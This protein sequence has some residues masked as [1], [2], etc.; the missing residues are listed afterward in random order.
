M[1]TFCSDEGQKKDFI[2]SVLICSGRWGSC[3]FI[4]AVMNWDLIWIWQLPVLPVL[5]ALSCHWVT[6]QRELPCR[7]LLPVSRAALL[8]RT[9]VTA[10]H[11][12]GQKV[13]DKSFSKKCLLTNRISP[14]HTGLINF[15][16]G[17]SLGPHL[18]SFVFTF[19]EWSVLFFFFF[20]DE[21][22]S[23]LLTF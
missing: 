15:C 9:G 19:P 5:P 14:K 3:L 8:P 16:F 6:L 22:S 10:P 12:A 11:W 18:K 21:F 23:Q 4:S 1:R 2:P 17:R 13:S 20:I 7:S